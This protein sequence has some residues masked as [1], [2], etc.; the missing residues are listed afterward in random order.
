MY[1]F[2]FGD[3][4]SRDIGIHLVELP[5]EVIASKVSNVVSLSGY[6][7]N[8]YESND[9]YIPYELSMKCMWDEDYTEEKRVALAQIIKQDEGELTFGYNS[10]WFFHAK[11]MDGIQI[12]ELT[13]DTRE[14]S[15]KFQVSAHRYLHSGKYYVSNIKQQ[16]NLYNS[17]D[18]SLPVIRIETNGG[19][20]FFTI[21]DQRFNILP[22]KRCTYIID[23][24]LEDVYEDGTFENLNSYYSIQNDFPILST[25]SNII[26]YSSNI[27]KLDIVPNWRSL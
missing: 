23:G 13:E 10:E 9:N 7:R 16:Q 11:V 5:N 2:K 27:L 20:A 24:V 15:L 1:Y 26:D 18:V 12:I 19:E 14:F 3:I 8:M 17:Y 22:G 21:N 25:G 6:D 4:D